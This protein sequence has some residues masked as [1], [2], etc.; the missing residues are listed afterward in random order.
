M[1]TSSCCVV[2][3]ILFFKNNVLCTRPSAPAI[4][5]MLIGAQGTTVRGKGEAAT[6]A[7]WR[8]RGEQEMYFLPR[9]HVTPHR[10]LQIPSEHKL[11]TDRIAGDLLP[12]FVFAYYFVFILST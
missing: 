8:V 4:I 10:A 12:T 1:Q 5:S 9:E 11:H 2:F 7:T 6:N 3:L